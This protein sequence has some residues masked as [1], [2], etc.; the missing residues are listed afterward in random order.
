MLSLSL[1]F[2]LATLQSLSASAFCS[3]AAPHVHDQN[4]DDKHD[5]S[6]IRNLYE[7]LDAVNAM[8]PTESEVKIMMNLM[9]AKHDVYW[10]QKILADCVVQENE[11]FTSLLK[12]RVEAAEKRLDDTDL[13]LGCMRIVF[14]THG[15]SVPSSHL[16]QG[17]GGSHSCGTTLDVSH[18]WCP[19]VQLD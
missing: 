6:G 8:P 1:K 10:A 18:G 11:A 7:V 13:G 14:N 15:W 19:M 4:R 12:F 9:R 2:N 3:H 5:G 16:P 17:Q